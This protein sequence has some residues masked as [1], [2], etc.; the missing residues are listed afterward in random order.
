MQQDIVFDERK[1]IGKAESPG[2][3]A[4]SCED[5]SGSEAAKDVEDEQGGREV[6]SALNKEQWPG[7]AYADADPEA[8]AAHDDAEAETNPCGH[9]AAGKCPECADE[10]GECS[11]CWKD[12]KGQAGW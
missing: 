10:Q 12:E 6:Q 2:D 11:E 1:D 8:G 4:G 3:E 9:A 5:G 7:A